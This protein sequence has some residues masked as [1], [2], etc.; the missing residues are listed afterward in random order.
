M[1]GQFT[2]PQGNR[3]SLTYDQRDLLEN[4]VLPTARRWLKI[5]G[6]ESQAKTTLAYWGEDLR[7][8]GAA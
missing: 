5:P 2:P 4:T 3:Q 6:L 8:G 7:S 1:D